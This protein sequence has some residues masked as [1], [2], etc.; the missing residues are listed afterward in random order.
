MKSDGKIKNVEFKSS[1]HTEER[2]DEVKVE[3]I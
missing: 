1:P 2:N 3:M